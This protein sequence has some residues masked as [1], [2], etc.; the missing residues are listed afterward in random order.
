MESSYPKMG[1][2][3]TMCVDDV[4]IFL[5]AITHLGEILDKYEQWSRYKINCAK[6]GVFF[7]CNVHRVTMNG[8]MD[9]LQVGY[10]PFKVKVKDFKYLVDKILARLSGWR[11]NAYSW[12]GRYAMVNFVLRQLPVYTMSTLKIP[13]EVCSKLDSIC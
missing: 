5:R 4:M 13:N 6:S 12:A 8:L 3:I 7:S 2:Y 11:K 1:P 10:L 9:F